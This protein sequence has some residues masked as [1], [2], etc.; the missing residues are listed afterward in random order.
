[1]ESLVSDEKHEAFIKHLMINDIYHRWFI[2]LYCKPVKYTFQLL[3]LPTCLKLRS[4]FDDQ[5]LVELE[6]YSC[7]KF[8]AK[9]VLVG[10]FY[11]N[12]YPIIL[13]TWYPSWDEICKV[14]IHLK[15]IL[16]ITYLK[17]LFSYL[18]PS[19]EYTTQE[20]AHFGQKTC[21]LSSNVACGKN[22]ESNEYEYGIKFYIIYF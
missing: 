11:S 15:F 12:D 4:W 10:W 16:Q 2:Q 7:K 13:H 6:T 21:K 22:G 14:V 17:V 18:Q 5:G 3:Y 19:I 20:S 1:M 9:P 8:I